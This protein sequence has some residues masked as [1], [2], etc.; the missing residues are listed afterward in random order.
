VIDWDAWRASYDELTFAEQQ[1]FY[2]RVFDEH[3]G[4]E[5]FSCGPLEK[6]LAHID[7]PLDIIEL[8]GWDG[9]LAAEVLPR[10][11]QIRSWTNYEI[12]PA[13]VAASVC[14]DTRFRAVLLGDWYWR[15]HHVADLFVA[16]H[17]L[18]HLRFRDVQKVFAVTHACFL[19]LEVPVGTEPRD[20]NGYHGSHILEVGWAVLG[21]ELRTHGYRE[22]KEL[23]K[24]LSA[25][26][27]CR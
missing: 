18:E 3:R 4:Q 11:P 10:Q 6:L 15:H 14:T 27:F 16:S 22:L 25:R 23:R 12:S 5:R 19:Y 8:G 20:W 1:T 9:G 2:N 13:A 7:K 17:V 24:G 26:S 21:D